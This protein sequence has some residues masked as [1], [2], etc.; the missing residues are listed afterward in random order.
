MIYERRI[1]D[2]RKLH[3]LSTKK[4]RGGATSSAPLPPSSPSKSSSGPFE[5][6]FE[7]VQ[8]KA[9]GALRGEHV[10][11][12]SVTS[13]FWDPRG[14]SIVSTSYDDTLRSEYRPDARGGSALT[15]A[16]V[17]FGSST[18]ENTTLL[19]YSPH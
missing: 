19:P 7:T 12:K 6:D 9:S 4:H 5:F 14:R 16:D 13:A 2:S 1:W 15:G 10:H 17:K 11:G 8:K 3:A 18:R